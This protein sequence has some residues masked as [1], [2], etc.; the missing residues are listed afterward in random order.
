MALSPSWEVVSCASTQ[1]FP[2]ILWNPKVHY[3]VHI[4]APLVPI[5]SQVNAV[6]TTQSHLI[7]IWILSTHLCLGFPS[8]VFS[9]GFPTNILYV[10]LLQALLISFSLTWSLQLYLAMSA[11][12]EAPHYAVF[13]NLLSFYLYSSVHIPKHKQATCSTVA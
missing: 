11:S 13:S 2:N 6:H 7:S 1:E 3:R 8:G 12:Y 10:L 4:S 5:L 9:Y